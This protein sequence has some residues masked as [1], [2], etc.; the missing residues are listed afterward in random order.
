MSER[1]A[2]SAVARWVGI[3]LRA[4][5]RYAAL[6]INWRRRTEHTP[7]DARSM[8]PEPSNFWGLFGAK[9][10]LGTLAL[11]SAPDLFFFRVAFFLDPNAFAR[12]LLPDLGDFVCFPLHENLVELL[13]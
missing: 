6:K 12:H 11:F 4:V 8:R 5:G 7:M 9:I 10:R 13:L 2:I 3:R 1:A